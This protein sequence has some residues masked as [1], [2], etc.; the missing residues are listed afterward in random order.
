M[1]REHRLCPIFILNF[2]IF[3]GILFRGFHGLVRPFDLCQLFGLVDFTG[4]PSCFFL[5]WSF[6]L[7]MEYYLRSFEAHTELYGF[8]E[9]LGR[10]IEPLY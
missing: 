1:Q 4:L 5:V 6:I 7:H 8:S 3:V 10:V 2:S 9:P